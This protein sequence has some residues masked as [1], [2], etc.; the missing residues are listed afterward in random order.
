M[1]ILTETFGDVVVAHT[2]DEFTDDSAHLLANTLRR[3][4]ENGHVRVVLQ[5]DRSDT[6]DSAGLGA[7]ADL[8]DSLRE[9]G[10]GLKV[11]CLTE[12]GKK[13]FELV[14]FNRRLDVFDSVID[15]VSSYR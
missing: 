9:S 5:M 8:H 3:G 12:V 7:L 11:C 10:G 1:H 13:V 4:A 2:P 6:F 15:A 14:R